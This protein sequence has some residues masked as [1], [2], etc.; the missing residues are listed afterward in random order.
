MLSCARFE[1][2]PNHD[3]S[4][5]LAFYPFS[6]ALM[7]LILRCLFSLTSHQI[8]DPKKKN[9]EMETLALSTTVGWWV[10]YTKDPHDPFG[11]LI[12]INPVTGIFRGKVILHAQNKRKKVHKSA[13]KCLTFA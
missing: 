10:G 4:D 13:K 1:P 8:L 9:S 7:C 6:C 5:S 3:G 2:K 12:W 11:R